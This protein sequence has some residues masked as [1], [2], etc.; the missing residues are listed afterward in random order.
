MVRVHFLLTFLA[1]GFLVGAFVFSFDFFADGFLA[2]LFFGTEALCFVVDFFS[3]VAG[4][5]LAAGFFF[6]GDILAAGVLVFF[7]HLA[8]AGFF[9]AGTGFFPAFFSSSLLTLK[10]PEAPTPFV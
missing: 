4:L 1:A 10:D 9:F 8:A 7:S 3:F 6:A 2:V 5:G